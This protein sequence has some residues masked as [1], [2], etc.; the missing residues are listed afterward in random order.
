M[1]KTTYKGSGVDIEAGNLFVEL[2]KPLAKTTA[3]KNVL[4][5]IGGFSGA[6][7]LP[8]KKYK[9]PVLVAA[10]DGVGTKLKIAF[11]TG[12]LDTVGID[13]VAM[14]VNDIIA[15]GA[16]PLFF[17]DYIATSRL[18][19]KEAAEIIKGIVKGCKDAGCAL[20]GGETAEMPG[21]YR[22]DEFDLAGFA[23]GIVDRDKILDGSDVAPGDIVIGLASSGLHSNGYSL[24]RKVLLEKKRYRL[25]DSPAP[26]TRALA[27]ELLEPT[28]IY[29]KTVQKLKKEFHI[30]AIA[31]ITGG[32]LLE[33][34][35]RAIPEKCSVVLD[36]SKWKLPPIMDLIK[37]EGRIESEE[38]WRTFNC[39]IGFVLVVSAYSASSVIT[40]LRQLK[41]KA[42]Q[43][44]EIAKRGKDI[45]VIIR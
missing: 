21:F 3:N 39:G 25:G 2:I 19:P 16:D 38:M 18:N 23:V 5:K 17:L 8:L 7:E 12:R 32:G 34:I 22:R 14:N 4:G 11:M 36:S 13:L 10:T 1:G 30:K 45:G 40:R 33:N 37:K 27:E 43:I 29:V 42:Y 35:P 28:R 26:L 44:G 24:A 6:Y 9:K 15:S 31:H 20:L 41:E